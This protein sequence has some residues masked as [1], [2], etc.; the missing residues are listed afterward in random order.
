MS[1]YT[2]EHM[3]RIKKREEKEQKE[4]ERVLEIKRS[5]EFQKRQEQIKN[6]KELNERKLK[7]YL[8]DIKT[9][10]EDMKYFL[11]DA[12]TELILQTILNLLEELNEDNISLGKETNNVLAIGKE[13]KR[14]R[15]RLLAN[16]LS[17]ENLINLYKNNKKRD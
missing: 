15:K 8:E 2:K 7:S 9:Y 12:K 13:S 17:Y 1:I 10:K 11:N 14:L 3:E 16:M 6:R 4:K 5:R